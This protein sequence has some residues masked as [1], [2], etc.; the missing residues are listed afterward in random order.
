[1]RKHE[2]NY[3]THDLELAAV[4]HALKIRR[5]YL[6]DDRCE[7]YSDHKSLKY[8]FTQTNLNLR[9]HRWLELIKHYDIRINYHPRKANVVADALSRKKYCSVIFARRMRLEMCQEIIYLNLAMVNETAMAVEIE[10]TLEVE[11]RKA[12]LQDEKLREIQQHI[13]ENKTRDFTEDD[14]RTLWLGKRICVPN[15]KPIQELI[16]REAHDSAYSIHPGS[17]KMYKDLKT[18]YW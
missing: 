10:P 17:T 7:I 11:I 1:L 9:Q 12:Q 8:I 3:P 13:K 2:E 14:N 4:V 5:H 6:I 15:Q 16:L 18:R